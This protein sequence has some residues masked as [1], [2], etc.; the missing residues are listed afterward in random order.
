MQGQDYDL[1]ALCLGRGTVTVTW[2]AP[3][4]PTGTAPVVCGGDTVRVR[5]TPQADGPAVQI[6]LTPD[7]EATGRA[8]ITVAIIEFQ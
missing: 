6:R 8:G 3:G 7:A 5:V 4:C 1:L 2:Q